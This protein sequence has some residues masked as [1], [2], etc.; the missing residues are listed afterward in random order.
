MQSNWHVVAVF[1]TIFEAQTRFSVA[2]R[3]QKSYRAA[4]II[5]FSHPTVGKAMKGI[6]VLVCALL[7]SLTGCAADGDKGQWD[8]FWK[9]LRGD[10]MKMRND[11]P[12]MK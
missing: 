7:F 5:R 12:G 1:G 8:E 10:N 6:C 9:D 4:G 3:G 2:S 11:I